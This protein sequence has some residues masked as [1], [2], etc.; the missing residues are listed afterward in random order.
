MSLNSNTSPSQPAGADVP[1]WN[2]AVPAVALVRAATREEAI[3]I[4]AAALDAAG[5]EAYEEGRD[6]FESEPVS[7]SAEFVAHRCRS[8]NSLSD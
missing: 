3:A 5:F 1:V 4:V 7:A 8:S 2:V 6:A